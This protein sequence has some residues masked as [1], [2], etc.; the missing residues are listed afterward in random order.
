MNSLAKSLTPPL[1]TL[2]MKTLRIE[3]NIR[4][5]I[6]ENAVFIFWHGKMLGG[7]WALRSYKPGALVS[8]SKDGEL[9]SMLLK[10]WDYTLFRGSS[11]SGGKAALNELSEFLRR[12]NSGVITPDGPRG[13][14]EYIK[15]G[16]LI[17]SFENRIP[18][19]PVKIE[20]LS[21]KILEKSWDK[22]EV[23]LP[24]SRCEITFGMPVQYSVLLE[25]TE[26]DDFKRTL[27]EEM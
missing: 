21:K 14:A 23:P 19:V 20:Y 18:I 27:A 6:P 12:G 17:L 26:L 5:K 8:M 16:A 4:H 3:M 10:S 7:W 24:F 25:G 2:L 15:N 1:V 13:P 9:L 22:F 11:S